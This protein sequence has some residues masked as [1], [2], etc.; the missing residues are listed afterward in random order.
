MIKNLYR[1]GRDFPRWGLAMAEVGGCCTRCSPFTMGRSNINRSH[2]PISQSVRVCSTC[3][4]ELNLDRILATLDPVLDSSLYV[5]LS[6]RTRAGADSGA[7]LKK[8]L[9]DGIIPLS[10]FVENEGLSM[11][12]RSEEY[13]GVKNGFDHVASVGRYCKITLQVHS[14]LDAVGLTAVVSEK[15][16]DANISANVVAAYYHDHIFIQSDRAS[17]ALAI[18]SK[19]AIEANDVL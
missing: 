19:L 5:F 4:G 18:V 11:I 16:T 15:L 2:A 9:L 12:L 7:V 14:S 3:S 17:E 13:D 6:I 1:F 10:Y 8:L